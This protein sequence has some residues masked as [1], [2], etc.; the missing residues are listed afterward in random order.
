MRTVVLILAFIVTVVGATAQSYSISG[1]VYDS[2][3]Q[4]TLSNASVVL[5]DH[6]DSSLL[7]FTRAN[8]N[9]DFIFNGLSMGK[10]VLQI[11]YPGYAIFSESYILNSETGSIQ[12]GL[13]NIYSKVH[14]LSEVIVKQR[15]TSVR[16]KNDTT[17]FIADSFIV[18]D[19][20]NVE[21]LLKKL[22]GLSVDRKGVISS[23]G[24]VVRKVLV[25]GEEFF[26][27]DPT[28]ATRNLIARD[29]AKVQLY[30][31]ESDR[32]KLT[33]I[34]DGVKQKTV[35]LVL[36]DDSKRGYFGKLESGS[37]FDKYYQSKVTANKFSPDSKKGFYL[38]GD[39]TGKNDMN[40]AEGQDYGNSIASFDGSNIRINTLIDDFSSSSSEGIPENR[41]GA[42]MFNQ[43]Y[44]AG[45]SKNRTVNN[46]N[47]N[48]QTL[49][50]ERLRRSQYL[51]PEGTIFNPQSSL[52]KV[53]RQR[54]TFSSN[55]ELLLNKR[56]SINIILKTEISSLKEF[57]QQNGVFS[58]S[59]GKEFSN[60]NRFVNS[61]TRNSRIKSELFWRRSFQK[62]GRLLSV[63]GGGEWYNGRVNGFL[64]NQTNNRL[65][66]GLDS[67]STT[68]QK[69]D[70]SAN[71]IGLQGI[72]SFQEPINKAISLQLSYFVLYSRNDQRIISYNKKNTSY[73]EINLD[74]SSDFIFTTI[75][76]RWGVTMNHTLKKG[77]IRYGINIQSLNLQQQNIP[78]DSLFTRHFFNLLPNVNY[79]LRL[80]KSSSLSLTYTG[81]LQQP[82]FS[83]LQPFNNNNDPL[84]IFRGNP[85][86]K[87]AFTHSFS[88]N[89]SRSNSV[90]NS[91]ISVIT[92]V[93]IT[94]NAFGLNHLIDSFGGRIIT[95]INVNGNAIY[96]L[97][98]SYFRPF[99][100]NRLKIDFG[101]R[102]RHVITRNSING[103]PNTTTIDRVGLGLKVD[104]KIS[105]QIDTY[106]WYVPEYNSSKSTINRFNDVKYITHFIESNT[107][108]E[109]PKGWYFSNI[110][111]T[112][113]R[114]SISSVFSNTS[115]FLWDI[116]IEKKLS[117]VSDLW[118]IFQVNDLLNSRK[119]VDRNIGTNFYS[120]STYQTI[121]RY[122]FVSIRWRFSKNRTIN[123]N[124]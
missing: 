53:D 47:Y 83:Q 42:L 70:N 72:L 41:S 99:Q 114:P 98:I 23:M 86:L 107:H 10:Y 7:R 27:N 16:F 84:N 20:A 67:S 59:S 116:S 66:N 113:I 101:P 118:A 24:Q 60:Y 18:R 119:G 49:I 93:S 8:T 90:L 123:R 103:L 117:R 88:S 32:S 55:N 9:G 19:G 2:L 26:G 11:Y 108:F 64:F 58:D 62:S 35:N 38:S 29:I 94:N 6:K 50:S 52:A 110:V 4:Q 80:D 14:I 34:D 87:P 121:Q 45:D 95:P 15:T 69:K 51:L 104:K 82:N 96:G 97:T 122:F 36:K 56:N 77:S 120:E 61:D 65:S 63:S 43:K 13:I 100:S 92:N 76:N 5:L 73:D 54:V 102:Y 3:G 109:L 39:R 74:N 48:Q 81:N 17:E 106:L 111:T 37:D 78:K 68:D 75:Q 28:M 40:F 22:P 33:G 89:L 1:R 105:K 31:G 79:R 30:D 25:D 71:A 115:V 44:G 85:E 12:L 21:E 91:S 112:D 57:A 46:I 124:D